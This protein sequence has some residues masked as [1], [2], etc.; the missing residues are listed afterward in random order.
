MI[1]PTLVTTNSFLSVTSTL[2]PINVLMVT[3]LQTWRRYLFNTW[4][5]SL[6]SIEQI[7]PS[8]L[9]VCMF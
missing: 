6:I 8:Y 3:W 4:S 5:H 9:D 7:L 2:I 1:G